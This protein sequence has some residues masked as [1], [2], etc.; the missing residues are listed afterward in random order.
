L[1]VATSITETDAD[2]SFDTYAYVRSGSDR[3]ESA[4]QQRR[5]GEADPTASEGFHGVGAPHATSGAAFE[6]SESIGYPTH[7]AFVC[8]DEERATNR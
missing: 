2:P 8:H 1:S 7:T 3:A 4:V 6:P 5:R